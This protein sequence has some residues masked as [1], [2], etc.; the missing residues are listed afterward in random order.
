MMSTHVESQRWCANGVELSNHSQIKVRDLG[1]GFPKEEPLFPWPE[2]LDGIY[3]PA[4]VPIV[5]A[6]VYACTESAGVPILTGLKIFFTLRKIICTLLLD[7]PA[8]RLDKPAGYHL[9]DIRQDRWIS[10]F[11]KIRISGIYL[12]GQITI[13]CFSITKYK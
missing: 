1:P 4:A 10:N 3:S 13:L 5:C 8:I 12:S 11:A 7:Y 9:P 2:A 6:F